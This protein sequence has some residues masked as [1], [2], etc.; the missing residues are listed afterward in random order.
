MAGGVFGQTGPRERPYLGDVSTLANPPRVDIVPAYP[1]ADSAAVDAYIAAGARGLVIEAV[2]HGNAGT[3]VV[4]AVRQA[5]RAES[6]SPSPPGSR[7]CE[8]AP[9]T[10]PD[11]T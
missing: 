1:G 9:C 7:G 6:P 3:A 8:P 4:E 10:A 2:G 5:T 11:T